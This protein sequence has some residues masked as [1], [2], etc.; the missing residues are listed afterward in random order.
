MI[1]M[2]DE[3]FRS[4]NIIKIAL[5]TITTLF[6]IYFLVASKLTMEVII[7]FDMISVFNSIFTWNFL[8]FLLFFPL[9]SIIVLS[10]GINNEFSESL[11]L[12]VISLFLVLVASV[13]FGLN[14]Y[15]IIFLVLYFISHI[16]ISITVRNKAQEGYKN[17]YELA[18]SQLSKL[19][20]FLMIAFFLA[21]VFYILPNQ[22]QDVE[23]MEAGIVG[24]FVAEDLGPWI[25]TSYTISAQCTKANLEHLKK[26]NQ[27]RTL[28]KKTDPESIAFTE[29]LNNLYEESLDNKTDA[30]IK[31]LY[32]NLNSTE[33]KVKVIDTIKSIPLMTIIESFF[34]FF[35]MFF[36]TSFVYTYLSIIFLLYA[37]FI[38]IFNKIIEEKE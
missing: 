23:K 26:S 29:Y 4:K 30:E 5:I 35:F 9:P 25:G 7:I 27:F 14:L 18:S 38:Y 28:E 32:P 13:L 19:T 33:V 3:L 8:L 10:I 37:L 12:L 20:I 21:G 11:K 15:F 2:S 17:L 16:I 1:V 31:E 36:V 22:K 34:A 6:W 24:L